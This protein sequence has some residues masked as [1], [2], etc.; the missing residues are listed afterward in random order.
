M[1]MLL[2][3]FFLWAGRWKI[4]GQLPDL[5]QYIVIGGPHTSNWDFV[6]G[7][8]LRTVLRVNIRYLGKSEL[9]RPPFGWLF[10][11]LGGYPVERSR[12]GNLVDGVGEIF[13]HEPEFRL[14][15]A[16]EGTRSQV[17]SLKTGFY[18]IAQKAKVPI[19]F[20]GLDYGQRVLRIAPPFTPGKDME[21]DFEHITSLYQQS[22]G[23]HPELGYGYQAAG[24]EKPY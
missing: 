10:R 19:V 14:A 15:L 21:A 3:R 11:A 6:Y 2:S 18:Y 4:Q 1:L 24:K 9:F 22:Q 17:D 8:S 20:V 16:P 5:P 7:I 13:Q 12:Q 23:K